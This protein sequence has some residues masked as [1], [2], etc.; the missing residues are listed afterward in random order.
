MVDQTPESFK[1]LIKKW[2]NKI[3]TSFLLNELKS[4]LKKFAIQYRIDGKYWVDPD[5]FL[6][7]AK[8]FITNLVINTRKTKL[9]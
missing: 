7:S 2:Y 6:V 4:A 1:N 9:N 8:P 3:D 5:L